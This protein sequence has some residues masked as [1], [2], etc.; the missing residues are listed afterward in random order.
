[1]KVKNAKFIKK[2]F[3]QVYVKKNAVP[4]FRFGVFL[5]IYGLKIGE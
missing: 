4:I 5:S 1:M 2:L 3:S